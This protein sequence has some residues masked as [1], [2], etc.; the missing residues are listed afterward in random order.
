M[1]ECIYE[2]HPAKQLFRV[3]KHCPSFTKEAAPFSYFYSGLPGILFV[4]H[5]NLLLWVEGSGIT[6]QPEQESKSCMYIKALRCVLKQ[7]PTSL[8]DLV[9]GTRLS[10]TET[11]CLLSLQANP[12]DQVVLRWVSWK[13]FGGSCPS[14]RPR[15]TFQDLRVRECIGKISQ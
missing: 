4:P 9:F 8:W 13:G 12:A 5:K 14:K 2:Y 10:S 3:P 7:G 11:L 1:N 15:L 6:S